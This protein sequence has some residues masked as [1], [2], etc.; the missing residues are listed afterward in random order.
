MMD[1]RVSELEDALR[2]LIAAC[3]RGRVVTKPGCGIGGMTLEANLRG[4][5]INGVDAWTVELAREVLEKGDVY[6]K[7]I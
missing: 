3:D 6:T 1:N 7:T 5:N 4:S 2:K